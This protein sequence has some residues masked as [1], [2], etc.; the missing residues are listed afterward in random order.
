MTF[1]AWWDTGSFIPDATQ[2]ERQAL[3]LSLDAE[4][5]YGLPGTKKKKKWIDPPALESVPDSGL[6]S[7]HFNIE[8]VQRLCPPTCKAHM[9][10]KTSEPF[11][12]H[13]ANTRRSFQIAMLNRGSLD[14][15]PP[16]W[17]PATAPSKPS[18]S[19]SSNIS[20]STYQTTRIFSLSPLHLLSSPVSS[21]LA[22][23]Q[24][25]ALDVQNIPL[26]QR[27]SS[28]PIYGGPVLS[29]PY[30]EVE[31]AGVEEVLLAMLR[32][33]TNLRSFH[34]NVGGIA[35]PATIFPA[36]QSSAPALECVKIHSFRPFGYNNVQDK[37]YLCDSPLWKLS[38]LTSFSFVVSGLTSFYN[39]RLYVP[40]LVDMLARCP[41]L[42]ELELLL[43]HDQ[44]TD[45][46][47][48]FQ[49][50]WP[51]L[52]S[53]LLGGP[54]HTSAASISLD[55]SKIDVRAFFAA[56]SA[57]ERLYLSIHAKKGAASCAARHLHHDCTCNAHAPRWPPRTPPLRSGLDLELF[58]ELTLASPHIT[59][60]W[61]ALDCKLTLP[62]FK[63]FLE[64]LPQLKKLYISNGAPVPWVPIVRMPD[65]FYQDYMAHPHR[66]IAHGVQIEHNMPERT[67]NIQITSN[68]NAPSLPVQIPIYPFVDIDDP[69]GDALNVLR[70]L[71]RLAHLPNFIMFHAYGHE[72]LDALVDPVVRRLAARLQRLTF[73]EVIITTL[74]RTGDTGDVL[75]EGKTWLGIQRDASNGVC[76]GWNVLADADRDELELDYKSWGS[77]KW[78]L[79]NPD[80]GE[81]RW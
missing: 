69:L 36:L 17:N 33:M 7:N 29:L 14:F 38:N 54:K 45:L 53:L 30:T 70:V 63:V 25:A 76:I 71:P 50:R 58:R 59:S 68:P 67:V 2:A 47:A 8:Q 49:G 80:P 51:L 31:N 39:A 74:G 26:L 81:H 64:C 43:G 48:L 27:L 22:T 10:R 61:L 41:R 77:L 21:F 16:S 11:L 13:S 75:K 9:K 15:P 46:D 1:G 20:L 32:G 65:A 73:L 6:S 5:K 12:V 23:S 66:P 28:S 79:D 78:L 42:E 4:S 55:S 57:L 19:K 56:H 52:K 44:P 72:S 60:I 35:P 40:K 18:P 37:W 62:E 34:W 24:A 3:Q